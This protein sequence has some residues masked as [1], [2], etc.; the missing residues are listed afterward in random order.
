[1][2]DT[3]YDDGEAGLRDR[4]IHHRPAKAIEA[5][6][7]KAGEIS[8]VIITHLHWPDAQPFEDLDTKEALQTIR[9]YISR[10]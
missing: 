8:Q 2:V 4:P 9:H 3:G 1:M 6:G 7:L 10:K 5:L